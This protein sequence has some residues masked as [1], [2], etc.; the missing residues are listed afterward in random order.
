MPVASHSGLAAAEPSTDNL[1][2]VRRPQ[3]DST[4]PELEPTRTLN[5]SRA[6]WVPSLVFVV[7]LLITAV[8]ST[9]AFVVNSRT[10]D[11]L[12][13]LK[14][15]ETA[16]VLQV[17]LP[18]IQTPLS[19]AADIALTGTG[20]VAQRF[21]EA[22]AS[23]VGKANGQFSSAS[24][25]QVGGGAPTML[26]LVGPEPKLAQDPAMLTSFMQASV[27]KSGVSV[28]GLLQRPGR[29]LGYAYRP[30]SDQQSLV[31]YGERPLADNPMV[32]LQPGSAFS[33]LHFRL[34]LGARPTA[35]DLLIENTTKLGSPTS[36][37][38]VPFGDQ[39]LALYASPDGHLSGTLSAWLWW[40]ALIVGGIFSVI[41]AVVA[42]RLVRRRMVA[43]A[44]THEVHELL[45]EQ[46]AIAESLQRAL[47]PQRLPTLAGIEVA[48]RYLPGA[49]GVDVGGDWYDV[50]PLGER[51]LFFAV[52]DV[53]G[54][55]IEAAAVMASMH[56]AMRAFVS[57]GHSPAQV[58]HGLT[59]LLDITADD[60]FATVLCG[61]VDLG[62]QTVRLASAGHLPAL[63]VGPAGAQLLS[64]PVGP[65]IGVRTVATLDGQEQPLYEEAVFPLPDSGTLMVFTDGLVER[66][67]ESIDAGLE[68]LR[69]T[70]LGAAGSLDDVLAFVLDQVRG[71]SCDD[72]TAVLGARWQ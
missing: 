28:L 19:A 26:A 17:S 27:K 24:L 21:H 55:G 67:G 68:R 72:D 16:A 61:I 52:G 32:V 33:D 47:L 41:A 45:V 59:R 51:R 66:R 40:I 31:V 22:I 1:E 56:F 20:T 4:M 3:P 2:E 18:A 23:N 8:L 70:A 5:F 49:S 6:G 64:T 34:Y 10:E 29:Q 7:A 60:H 13:K 36:S 37:A 50:S 39:Q 71:E 38:F 15:K 69:A 58:L 46:S 42:Q 14:V 62:S 30:A 9:A 12:L 48:A 63:L 43:E 54:R 11:R 57:E 44:L 53:S 65:P 35:D 25:W